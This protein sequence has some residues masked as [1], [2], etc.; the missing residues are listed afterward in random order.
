MT[1]RPFSASARTENLDRLNREHFDILIIGGGITGTAAARDAALRGYSVAL[2]DKGDFACGTSSRSSRMIHGGLRYLEHYQLHLV[3][4]SV[5]ERGRLLRNAPRLVKPQ[6]FIY[7][8]YRRSHPPYLMLAIA[9]W[10]YDV[11]SL[12]G[13]RSLPFH[14]MLPLDRLAQTEPLIEH[15]A[16]TGAGRYFDA[17]VDDARFTLLT[18]RS[19]HH[20]GAVVANYVEAIGLMKIGNRIIGAHARDTLS[21]REISVQARVVVNAAGPWV[22]AVLGLD[23]PIRK[24]MLRPTKGAH[25]IVPHSRLPVR[26]AVVIRSPRDRRPLFVAPWGDLAIVGTTDTDYAERLEE[27]HAC[28]DDCAYLLESIH[29]LMPG[30]GLSESDVISAYAGVRPL[31]AEDTDDPS[32]VSREHAIVES[33]SG[34][35]TIAGGKYT[36]HRAMAEQLMDRV[37]K[38]LSV[39]SGIARKPSSVTATTPL[40]ASGEIALPDVPEKTAQHLVGA[41]GVDVIEVLRLAESDPALAEP[42]DAALPYLRAEVV[43]AVEHEMAVTLCDVLM[44][45]THVIYESIDGALL[46]S[47]AIAAQ[48]AARLGW[49]AVRMQCEVAAYE[50]QVGLARAFR[51]G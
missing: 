41:Y 47:G 34:L 6:P 9:L 39:D 11:M 17:T 22:D 28:R 44:R 1:T 21:G 48:M 37:Q 31:V 10:L 8:V 18:A 19:A 15:P 25:I 16:V 20:A 30:V 7:P 40:V 23:A 14:R 33:R 3:H 50:R 49:D 46:Q 13:G 51:K 27:V 42:I 29:A 24:S 36:T 38:K 35:I 12:R 26:E 2:I 43:Y 4:E 5:V 32:A 45:R